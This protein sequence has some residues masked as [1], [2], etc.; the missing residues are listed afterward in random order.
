M[1]QILH[2]MK[3]E[4]QARNKILVTEGVLTKSIVFLFDL[5]S[6]PQ[7]QL[8]TLSIQHKGGV[9]TVERDGNLCQ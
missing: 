6:N 3:R 8:T 2:E 1:R 5:T 9:P 7:T 4:L